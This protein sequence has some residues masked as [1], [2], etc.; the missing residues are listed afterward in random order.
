MQYQ[1][2]F[3]V[4][5]NVHKINNQIFNPMCYENLK[6]PKKWHLRFVAVLNYFGGSV[7]RFCFHLEE[8]RFA[9]S[10]WKVRWKQI[11]TPL[12]L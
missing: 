10:S 5:I 12:F 9:P 6:L 1:R 11:P 4:N 7:V 2:K 3:I 8:N